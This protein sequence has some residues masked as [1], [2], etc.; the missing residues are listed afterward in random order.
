M[1]RVDVIV[2]TRDTRELTLRCVEGVVASGEPGRLDVGCVVVDN[3]SRD[4]TAD[5]IARRWPFVAV[6]SNESDVG[7]A[8]ACNLGARAGNAEYLLFLNSDAFP[9]REAI[10]RLVEFLNAH[11]SHA[12]AGG[13]LVDA[14]TER[15]QVGFAVRG[16]PTVARQVALLI[17][18]ERLWPANPVS[19]WQTLPDFDYDRTQDVEAQPAGACLCC[20]RADFEAAGAF[21]EGFTYWF[22]DI[23]LVRRLR[24][25]GRI[26][27]VHDAVF[28]HVG[29]ATFSQWSRSQ[30]LAARYRGLL[31]YF[32]KHHSTAAVLTLRTVIGVLATVRMVGLAALAPARARAYAGVLRLALRRIPR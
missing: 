27:Y 23:D 20:R 9:R 22:E 24:K 12:L 13:R 7:Y 29:G 19:R 28:D 5:A 30:V 16:F 21:D 2:P 25:A 4:G 10:A 3:A 11:P 32:E 6:V 17:G 1:R 14:G 31:R 8:R 26:A 15:A 18:L